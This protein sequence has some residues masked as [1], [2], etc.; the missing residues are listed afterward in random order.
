M[1]IFVESGLLN[2]LTARLRT[3]RVSGC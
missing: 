2:D 3:G 1:T